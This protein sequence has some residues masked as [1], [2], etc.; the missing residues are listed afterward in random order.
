MSN[1]PV[2][3]TSFCAR[4]GAELAPT[5]LACPACGRLI[6]AERL[7]ALAGDAEAATARGDTAGA[8]AAWRE[9]LDLLPASSR[10]RQA[11]AERINAL[12][13]Q[14]HAGIAPLPTPAV[15][16][17]S[18]PGVRQ[19]PQST[20]HSAGRAAAGAAGGVALLLWKF[21]FAAVFLLTKGKLLLLGLTKATTLFSMLLSL[22][23]Y[24]TIWGWKFA[25]GLVLS[26]YVHEMG[27][28]FALRRYGFKATAP[29]FI[30]GLGA[31]IR[32]QQHPANPHEDAVIGLAGP[33]YGLLAAAA[34]YGLF[35]AT[36]HPI[37]AAI[38]RVGAWINLFNLLPIASLDGGRAFNALSSP[39][40]WLATASLGVAW[41]MSHESLLALLLIVAGMRA[42]S[43]V[44]ASNSDPANSS[45]SQRGDVGATAWYVGL[46]LVLA[47]MCKIPVPH[48]LAS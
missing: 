7:S 40:R 19:S 14:V 28:V 22:G 4:C 18:T 16:S 31:L 32:L 48:G 24:W 1:V 12:S 46:V 36:G 29:T 23:V 10:Q 8:L 42:I 17:K 39:Q 5:L 35:H 47:V 37:F 27:H 26:I 9:A 41:F 20:S 38:A 15:P 45:N 3:L 30:P 2:A 6:H 13:A 43:P 25:L 11:V 44:V 33:I 21:K 34:A